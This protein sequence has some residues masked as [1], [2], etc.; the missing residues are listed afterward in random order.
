M[1]PASLRTFHARLAKW[2]EAHGRHTLPWRQTE[3]AYPIWV[4]E[5]MLQQTQVSTVLARFYHPFLAKFPTIEALA[6]APREAVM[7]AWE[8][9]GYYRRAGY[10]HAAAQQMVADSVRHRRNDAVRMPDTVEGLRALPGIGQNTAHAILA[11]AYRRPVAIMEANLKRI[12]ARIFALEMPTEPQRWEGAHQLLNMA[13][14]FDYNQAM[15]DL[16]SLVCLPKNPDCPSCPANLICAG[17][18][19]PENYPAPRAKKQSPTR[20]VDMIVREDAAGQLYLE[21]RTTALL[22]GMYGFPQMPRQK[23]GGMKILGHV[24]HVYSHFRLEGRVLHEKLAG[25]M[26]GTHWHTRDTLDTLALSAV[27]HKALALV[28]KC[29]SEQKKHAKSAPR[30][31]KR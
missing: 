23:I 22:G 8:G 29:N 4:S 28:D 21:P 3:D 20:T 18:I 24:T 17:K 11:F 7:K 27:D 16:G 6:A 19:A 31:V 1:K 10:L 12:V 14:P 9:L 13:E 5:V 26:H 30:R 25:I 15:M 2:Y